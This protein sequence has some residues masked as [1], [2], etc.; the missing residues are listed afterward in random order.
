MRMWHLYSKEAE[1]FDG[2]L[3]DKYDGSMDSVMIFV[4]EMIYRTVLI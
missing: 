2:E 1:D 3:Y 4:G